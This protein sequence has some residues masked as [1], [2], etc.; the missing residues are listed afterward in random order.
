MKNI[1]NH[2]ISNISGIKAETKH[3]QDSWV[4]NLT[5]NMDCN[6]NLAEKA[7]S[8]TAGFSGSLTMKE[9]VYN[10][11]VSSDEESIYSNVNTFVKELGLREDYVSKTEQNTSK[12][13]IIQDIRIVN[14]G[15]NTYNSSPF[16]Q[17]TLNAGES[18][19]SYLNNHK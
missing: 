16:P 17:H 18:M 9:D 15:V 2:Q 13:K 12:I 7:Y 5:S 3:I 11:N 6:G 4:S 1:S 8:L 19:Y 10:S 14:S